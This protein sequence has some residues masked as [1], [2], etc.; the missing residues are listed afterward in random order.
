MLTKI[1][2]IAVAVLSE[3][4]TVFVRSNTGIVGLNPARGNDICVRVF[5]VCVVLCIGSGIATGWSSVQGVLTTLY[6]IRKLKSCQCLW[7]CYLHNNITNDKLKSHYNKNHSE[8]ITSDLVQGTSNRKR[9][10]NSIRK[11][12]ITWYCDRF[13]P[14]L[15]SFVNN[16]A[17]WDM[18]SCILV[19]FY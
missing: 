19:D 8:N 17:F 14:L 1:Q 9:R 18:R 15:R 7:I 13:I 2:P 10:G 16:S 4:W 6:K 12:T 5:C 3:G 11:R